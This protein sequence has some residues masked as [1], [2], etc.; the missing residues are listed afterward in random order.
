[1][2]PTWV[3]KRTADGSYTFF[4]ETFQEDFHS[5]T[6]A[7][8]EAETKYVR[9][10]RL[11]ERAQAN[12]LCLLDV[13]Y[14]LG[15]NTA[16][17]L[18]TIW[19]VNPDC[20]VFWYGLE[21]DASVPL[22]VVEAGLLGDWS[23]Q[24]QTVLEALARN[25]TCEV[26]G[27][28]GHLLL[29]DARQS[30]QAVLAPAFLADAIFLDPF[31]PKRCP[32]LWSVE[33]LERVAHALAPEGTLVTYSRSAA[34]RAAL[35]QAGLQIGSIPPLAEHAPHDWSLG[36]VAQWTSQGLPPL[37]PAEQDHLHTRAAVPF[38]DP[39]LNAAAEALQQRRQQEQQRS[40]L[41]STSSW[42]RHWGIP[43]R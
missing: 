11:A 42:R 33:F 38:R 18:E 10:C 20:Q 17:A 41:R 22:A 4:S 2:S 30:I 37:P 23:A 29:G 28:H 40:S 13:C 8:A 31:S 26:S 1:M 5:H 43:T 6:G 3:P 36:T 14:G 25:H 7:K 12:R 21:L 35:R 19:R 9:W 24:V 39:D 16:A 34:V 15:Y 32:Q 27:F